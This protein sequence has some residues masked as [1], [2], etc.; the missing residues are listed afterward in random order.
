M[1]ALVKM[2]KWSQELEQELTLFLKDWLKQ[3]G[4]TQAELGQSLNAASSRMSSLLEVL[5]KEF[6]SGGIPAIASRLCEIEH[7]WYN[8]K[9]LFSS[10]LNNS[11]PFGQ[12]DLLLEE[13]KEDCDN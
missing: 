12:L 6:N 11:D 10:A 1:D 2:P 13:I 7:S 4:K 8:E 3:I 9:N 5:K